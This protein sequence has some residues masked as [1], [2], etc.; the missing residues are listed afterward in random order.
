LGLQVA[1]LKDSLGKLRSESIEV[2]EQDEDIKAVTLRLDL[3]QNAYIM[4]HNTFASRL[5]AFVIPL[6][7][8]TGNKHTVQ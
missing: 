2:E 5:Y 7:V 1:T 3:L 8:S 6:A 4:H